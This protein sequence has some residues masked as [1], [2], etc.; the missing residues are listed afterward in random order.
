MGTSTIAVTMAEPVAIPIV[1][2]SRVRRYR[3]S[4]EELVR[5]TSG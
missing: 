1:E 5:R 2:K 4:P 3:T